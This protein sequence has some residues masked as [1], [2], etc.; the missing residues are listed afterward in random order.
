MSL[1]LLEASGF[2]IRSHLPHDIIKYCLFNIGLFIILGGNFHNSLHGI[3]FVSC[4]L[5]NNVITIRYRNKL[6]LSLP[7][8]E[9]YFYR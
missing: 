8:G 7:T 5:K 3:R 6:E 1:Q 9:N 4:S 2:A